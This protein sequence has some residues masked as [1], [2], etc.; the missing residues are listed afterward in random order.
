MRNSILHAFPLGW[1]SYHETGPAHLQRPFVL[2]IPD[3]M[4]SLNKLL[5]HHAC[6]CSIHGRFLF[7]ERIQSSQAC[8]C[9]SGKETRAPGRSESSAQVSKSLLWAGGSAVAPE[10]QHLPAPCRARIWPRPGHWP[11]HLRGI[12]ATSDGKQG[13]LKIL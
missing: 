4:N 11:A 2:N 13:A 1:A 7:F 10:V 9:R 3:F 8:D 5:P 6:F 12:I